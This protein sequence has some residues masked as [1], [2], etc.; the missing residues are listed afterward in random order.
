MTATTAPTT[1]APTDRKLR[2]LHLAR[3]V[4]AIAWALVLALVPVRSGA[5]LT[6]LLVLYPLVDAVAVLIGLRSATPRQRPGLLVNVV[7][8][9]FA[10]VALGAASTGSVATV[11]TVWGGWAAISGLTQLLAALDRS[12]G[13]S[14]WPLVISGGLSVLVGIGFVLQGVR[15][16]TALTSIAGYAV[17]GGVFFLLSALLAGR[18]R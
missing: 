17:A 3:F 7:I 10:A 18:R 15:G 1:T 4:F 6:V 12:A 9:I 13:R 14:R 5:P 16:G 2:T 11:L 8:S